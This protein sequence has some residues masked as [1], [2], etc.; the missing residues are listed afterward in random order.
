[1]TPCVRY[2]FANLIAELFAKPNVQIPEDLQSVL[3][4]SHL[5]K[6]NSE[7]TTKDILR[8]YGDIAR[9]G[10]SQKA[11]NGG[12]TFTITNQSRGANVPTSA[13][14]ETDP[15][16]DA[17]SQMQSSV[18]HVPG[19]GG[20]SHPS[21]AIAPNKDLD[22]RTRSTS[23]GSQSEGQPQQVPYRARPNPGPMGVAG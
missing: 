4:D 22:K 14:I 3:S 17:A 2:V 10:F 15:Y 6:E 20:N 9:G 21:G 7:V 19:P 16:Q 12:E 18:R 11:S 1:M 5:F 8:R 23:T 13:R